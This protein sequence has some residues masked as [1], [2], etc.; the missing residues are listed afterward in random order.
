MENKIK[1]YRS[2]VCQVCGWMYEEELGAPE[3]GIAA[4]TRWE[5]IPMN[6]VCPECGARK[7]DFEMVEV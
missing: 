3:E 5:D 7:E 2:F 6:W 4:G 1:E